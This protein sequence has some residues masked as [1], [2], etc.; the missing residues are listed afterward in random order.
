M[1]ME[2]NNGTIDTTQYYINEFKGMKAYL[3]KRLRE[4]DAVDRNPPESCKGAAL[5]QFHAY[6]KGAKDELTIINDI[7][8]KK[9]F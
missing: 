2:F 6:N 8:N 4:I 9:K 3:E 5:Q 7:L 1:A